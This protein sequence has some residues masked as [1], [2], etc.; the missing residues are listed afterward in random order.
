MFNQLITRVEGLSNSAEA[1][2]RLRELELEEN[3]RLVSELESR[4]KIE[5]TETY[6]LVNSLQVMVHSHA[7]TMLQTA[8]ISLLFSFRK[9]C[10]EFLSLLKLE[11]NQIRL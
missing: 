11:W 7:H 10:P 4:R 5:N 8:L 9:R 1:W 2:A 3:A 6:A